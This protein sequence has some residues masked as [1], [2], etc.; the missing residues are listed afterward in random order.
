[1]A[2]ERLDILLVNRK[3]AESRS[4]AQKLIMAGD[5]LVNGQVA[6]KPSQTFYDSIEIKLKQKP[7]YVSR[8]GLKLEKALIEF[9]LENLA[10]KIC[11]DVGASTGGFTD[12]L[13]K[14]QAVK[15]FA[16]DVGYGQIHQS[17]RNSSKVVL[18]EKTNVREIKA[19]PE[20]INF[21][22]I[23]VSFIS[24][25]TVL[26]VI[27]SWIKKEDIQVI[28]LVKPQF[29]AGRKEAAKG[30][31]VIRSEETRLAIIDDLISFAKSID[32]KYINHVESPVLGPKGNK[33][34]LLYL[35]IPAEN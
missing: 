11:V 14:H 35:L 29:E 5:I 31:G 34:F 23:D 1:M 24:L 30:K 8:G 19:F 26:P 20:Q 27:K 17:L 33:E 25:K 13:L 32:L 3:F 2:K 10:G 28:A 7:K 18:M 9:G 16:I 4:L 12:C 15:V 6:Y 22:T 21:V